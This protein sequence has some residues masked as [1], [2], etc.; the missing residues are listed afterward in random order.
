MRH[1]YKP[2]ISVPNIPLMTEIMRRRE[3][4]FSGGAAVASVL[5]PDASR[6]ALG[7]MQV[8]NGSALLDTKLLWLEHEKKVP[9]LAG[10]EK[11]SHYV[12]VL[13]GQVM[14]LIDDEC[15]AFNAGEVWWCDPKLDGI[16][17]NKSGDDAVLL[18]VSV[19][20]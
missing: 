18:Y 16:L 4:L 15:P 19:R 1:F 5:P 9:I 8:T 11:T 2:M 7:I 3:E 20:E 14:C 12:S 6:M 10:E 17:L 13:N